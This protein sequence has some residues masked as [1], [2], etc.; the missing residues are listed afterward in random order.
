[1]SSGKKDFFG[2]EVTDAIKEAC[3]KLKVPQEELEI[4]V[5]ETGSMGIFGL[6]RKKAHI[7]ASVKRVSREASAAKEV[8]AAVV[9]EP[10]SKTVVDESVPEPIQVDEEAEEDVQEME[11]VE[12]V[13]GTKVAEPKSTKNVVPKAAPKTAPKAAVEI[14]PESVEIVRQE[15]SEL[16][17][18]MGFESEVTAELDGGTVRCRV[19]GDHEEALT[20]Q[21]GK[22]I[23]SM[24]YLLR[25]TI[26]RKV[27]EKIRLSI[28]IG[29]FRENRNLE[30]TE[31]AKE[32]A[33]MLKKQRAAEREE[34]L[35]AAEM[36]LD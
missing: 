9:A 29:E 27:D 1:M 23:D 12:A 4:E 20:G 13:E 19:S 24:Q 8:E 30:L 17:R 2:K 14:L 16:L 35:Q 11:E 7:R 18:L 6:I 28:D 32:L 22:I 5:V 26:A 33:A 21:E 36:E 3:Q 15:L 25:K 10:L 34:R 31:R